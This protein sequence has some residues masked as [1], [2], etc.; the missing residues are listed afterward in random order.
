M[1]QADS[2]PFSV[3]IL[4]AGSVPPWFAGM[5][6]GTWTAISSNTIQAVGPG[7]GPWSGNTGLQGVI[8]AWCGGA[9]A[10]FKGSY[11]SL[12]CWG[13]GHR[14]YYGSE[15][16]AFDLGT[17]LWS[18]LTSP[19]AGPYN[20]PVSSAVWPDGSPSVAHTY[21]TVQYDPYL[22]VFIGVRLQTSNA[23][24][25]LTKPAK[26]SFAANAVNPAPSNCWTYGAQ[27]SGGSPV[28]A[29]SMS[30]YDSKRRIIWCQASTFAAYN[31]AANT[32]T[33]YGAHYPY[34]YRGAMVYVPP[35]DAII[36]LSGSTAAP[37]A[38]VAYDPTSPASQEIAVSS[39]NTPAGLV[40]YPGWSWSERRNAILYWGTGG[41]V[42]EVVPSTNDVRT[43]VWDWRRLTATSNT[44]APARNPNGTYGRFRVARWGSAEAAVVVSSTSGSVYAFR[45]P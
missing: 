29:G 31:I 38:M 17:Q 10:T 24:S 30:C 33:D 23:P 19:Y 11:G 44:V 15:V 28:E 7:A 1:A 35:M 42:Y 32:W 18:R 12:I 39:T 37:G 40:S 8:D 34:W 14:D 4:P 21:N 26:F 22:N 16:Y 2:A 25:T 9:F 6:A 43:A 5:T 36:A 45:V 20:F 27:P 13:G 3:S 41:N